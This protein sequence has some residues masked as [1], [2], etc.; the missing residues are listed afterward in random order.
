M[1]LQQQVKTIMSKRMTKCPIC[2]APMP[3][4]LVPTQHELDAHPQDFIPD[5]KLPALNVP[6]FSQLNLA[7]ALEALRSDVD[8]D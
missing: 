3:L 5:Y 6:H 2:G 7:G 4:S 8:E 1:T